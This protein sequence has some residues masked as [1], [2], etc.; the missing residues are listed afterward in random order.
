MVHPRSGNYGERLYWVFGSYRSAQFLADPA[1]GLRWLRCLP[2]HG[3]HPVPFCLLTIS[4]APRISTDNHPIIYGMKP[5]ALSFGTTQD[6]ERQLFAM[7]MPQFLFILVA[8]IATLAT[9]A[10]LTMNIIIAQALDTWSS[11]IRIAATIGSTLEAIL[12]ILLTV[13]FII[14]V[15]QSAVHTGPSNSVWLALQ[16]LAS[17]LAA[18][19]SIAVSISMSKATDLPETLLGVQR[20]QYMIGS[21]IALG[22]AFAGQL[23]FFVYN[24]VIGRFLIPGNAHSLHKESRYTPE[25]RLKT[26]PYSKT[27]VNAP[28]TRGRPSGDYQSR[29]GTGS[30]RSV[31]ETMSSIRTSISQT[32]RPFSSRT[33]LLSTS[34]RSGRGAGSFDSTSYRSRSSFAQDGFDSWDTS[35]VEPHRRQPTLDT[36]SAI[37]RRF[38]ETIPAS[39]TTSRS[40]SPGHPLDLEP[41]KQCRRSRSY[42]PVPIVQQEYGMSPQP[43]PGELHIHPLFRTDSPTPPPQATP[44][45]VV[46]AAPNAGKVISEKSLTRMRSGS[47]PTTPSPLSRQGSFDSYRRKTPSP[48]TDGLFPPEEIEER[49]MTPPIPEWILSAGSRTSLTE[50]TMRK[51]RDQQS[52]STTSNTES[53]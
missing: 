41:P 37:S 23:I 8:V 2:S 12:L 29:P 20:T 6:L 27:A 7:D 17:V 9:A 48:N 18:A 3:A 1:S 11:P 32:V 10:T 24:Q 52:I 38:L 5:T 51:L 46:I 45:T 30:S 50:Y 40:P 16:I 53:L 35:A 42:S 4:Y 31:T 49:K 13:L 14:H 21:A 15:R 34:S 43:C 33:R 47:L 26:I 36:F 44:G 25:M 39:P 22:A 28:R 19:S